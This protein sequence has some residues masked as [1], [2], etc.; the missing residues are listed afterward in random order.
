MGRYVGAP[1][2][3]KLTVD[4]ATEDAL[5][6]PVDATKLATALF[7]TVVSAESETAVEDEV[8]P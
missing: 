8:I 7:T 5:T 2:N 6:I 4:T 1:C 3:A